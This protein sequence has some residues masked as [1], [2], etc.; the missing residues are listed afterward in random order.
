MRL[1]AVLAALS[2]AVAALAV[3]APAFASGAGEGLA[4]ETNDK[5]VTFFCLCVLLFFVLT[6]FVG[7][8]V[9]SRLERRKDARK[10]AKVRQRVGW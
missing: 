2:T 6:I 4:G 8:F 3:T 9:Q 1:R 10:A 5:V 7:T